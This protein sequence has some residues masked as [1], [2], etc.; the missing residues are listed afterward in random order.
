M[1]RDPRHVLFVLD[2]GQRTFTT[3]ETQLCEVV[4]LQSV[5]TQPLTQKS[6]QA[7]YVRAV[8]RGRGWDMK[9]HSARWGGVSARGNAAG[10]W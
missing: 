9:P 7:A 2:V 1:W 5:K 10:Q 8:C 4:V 6:L 3:V